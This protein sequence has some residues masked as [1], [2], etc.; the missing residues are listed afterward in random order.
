MSEEKEMNDKLP[1]KTKVLKLW[2][3]LR[4]GISHMEQFE[5]FIVKA[6]L[7]E[8]TFS[9]VRMHEG[10]IILDVLSFLISPPGGSLIMPSK[11]RNFLLINVFP[12]LN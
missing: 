10:N 5:Y 11:S 7:P 12:N 4:V 6:M 2:H 3:L 8:C 1:K 9:V